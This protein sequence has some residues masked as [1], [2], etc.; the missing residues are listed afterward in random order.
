MI[1]A[2][3]GSG[4][5]IYERLAAVT[6]DAEAN[7]DEKDPVWVVVS[8]CETGVVRRS[9]IENVRLIDDPPGSASVVGAIEAGRVFLDQRVDAVRIAGSNAESDLADALGFGRQPVACDAAPAL[10]AVMGDVDSARRAATLQVPGMNFDLPR[11]CEQRFRIARIHDQVRAAG[12]LI[13]KQHLL[14]GLASIHGL[15][16]S[17][18][19]LRFM[20]LAGSADVHD[21]GIRRMDQDASDAPGFLQSHVMPAATGVVRLVDSVANAHVRTNDKSLTRAGPHYV[22]SRGGDSQRTDRGNVLVVE[23]RP[24]VRAILGLEDAARRSSYIGDIGIAGLA[25]DRG[26]AIA[27]DADGSKAQRAQWGVVP[28]GGRL[29]ISPLTIETRR[30]AEHDKHRRNRRYVETPSPHR[31]LEPPVH[32]EFVIV[33]QKRFFDAGYCIEH[34]SACKGLGFWYSGRVVTLAGVAPALLPVLVSSRRTLKHRQECL[35]HKIN[36]GSNDETLFSRVPARSLR[37]GVRANRTPSAR[38]GAAHRDRLAGQ[39]PG[40]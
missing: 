27:H 21:V 11:A 23:D 6:G 5:R 26:C 18:F 31:H 13:H 33:D 22:V 24:V 25:D 39:Q 36:N 38:A 17:A 30:S 14:P 37:T 12:I 4:Q 15:E 1:V 28:R 10:S 16:D 20:H 32:K 7:R 3:G 9:L 8:Y 2:T 29:S 40:Q 35:C 34:V 19:A